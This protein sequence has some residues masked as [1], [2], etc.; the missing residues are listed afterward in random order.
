MSKFELSRKSLD[1][2]IKKTAHKYLNQKLQLS[3][4][5]DETTKIKT[6]NASKTTKLDRRSS[7]KNILCLVKNNVK[8]LTGF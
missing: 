4:N 1:Y 3:D 5:T 7:S 6:K 8:S 2:I